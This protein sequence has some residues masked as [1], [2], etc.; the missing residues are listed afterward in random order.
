VERRWRGWGDRYD[1]YGAVVGLACFLVIGAV[2]DVAFEGGP[3]AWLS[4]FGVGCA[5]TNVTSFIL[6][7]RPG[8]ERAKSSRAR[9]VE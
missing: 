9:Q 3:A 5:V 4:A 7:R 2:L 8:A 1:G 6:R